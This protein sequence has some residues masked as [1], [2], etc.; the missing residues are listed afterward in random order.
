[1][2]AATA[3]NTCAID[4][5]G[6]WKE[7]TRVARAMVRDGS[8]DPEKNPRV[9]TRLRAPSGEDRC[10]EVRAEPLLHAGEDPVV[11][12]AVQRINNSAPDPEDVQDR[13]DLSPRQAQVALLLADRLTTK[14]IAARMNIKCSTAR[15]HVEMVLMRLGVHRRQEVRDVIMAGFQDDDQLRQASSG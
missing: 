1:M 4:E 15:H 7:I 10:Y 12:L 3:P 11:M 6:V 8:L 9:R 14:E 5:S 2:I 13:F